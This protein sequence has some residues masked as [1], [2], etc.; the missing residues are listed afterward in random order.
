[1]SAWFNLV[2]RKWGMVDRKEKKGRGGKSLKISFALRF[3]NSQ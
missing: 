1:M 2:I 3:P